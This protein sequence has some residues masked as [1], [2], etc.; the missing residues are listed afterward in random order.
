MT[1]K[2]KKINIF[3]GKKVTKNRNKTNKLLNSKSNTK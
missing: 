3:E 2:L 1:N